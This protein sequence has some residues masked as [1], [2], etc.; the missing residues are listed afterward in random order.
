VV[1]AHSRGVLRSAIFSTRRTLTVDAA[2]SALP[3]VVAKYFSHYH[4]PAA[5]TITHTI[6]NIH[7]S[8]RHGSICQPRIPLIALIRNRR[9]KMTTKM[10]TIATMT[11]RVDK[12]QKM[13]D[14]ISSILYSSVKNIEGRDM[15]K[16]IQEAIDILHNLECQA[17]AMFCTDEPST[18][19]TAQ[20]DTNNAS[21]NHSKIS[22]GDENIQLQLLASAAISSVGSLE[23]LVQRVNRSRKRSRT[24]SG[25]AW[26]ALE[27]VVSSSIEA[28]SSK[29]R[30]SHALALLTAGLALSIGSTDPSITKMVASAVLP[31]DQIHL[32]QCG[33]KCQKKKASDIATVEGSEKISVEY[34]EQEASKKM[35][36]RDNDCDEAVK[37]QIYSMARAAVLGLLHLA[38]DKTKNQPAQSPVELHIVAKIESGFS[39]GD[40]GRKRGDKELAKAVANVVNFIFGRSSTSNDDVD[41]YTFGDAGELISK[42]LVAP[43]FSLVANIRPWDYV[44][45]EHLVRCA[46]ELDLWYSAELL[47]DA[48]IATTTQD[49]K[50]VMMATSFSKDATTEALLTDGRFNTSLPQ[51]SIGH[52]AAGAIIDITF[53]YRLYRRADA[54]ATKYYSFGGPER[55]VEA[56]FLHACD[57]ITKVVKRRQVQVIDKQIERVDA[58]VARVSKDLVLTSSTSN[59]DNKQRKF[60]GE[61]VAIETMSEHIRQ[62]TLRSLRASSLHAAAARLAKLWGLPY[63]HDPM[64]MAQELEARKLLYLQWDDECCPGN[65]SDTGGKEARPLPEPI[66][67]PV[68]VLTRFSEL[69]NS[70]YVGFD[71]EWH[72]TIRGVALLQLSTIGD[73]LLIDIPALTATKEGCDSLRDTVGKLFT[74]PQVLGV[75]EVVGFGCKDDIKRLRVSPCVASTHWFPQ[76]ERCTYKD[77]RHLIRELNPQLGGKGGLGF[78]LSSACDMF[79][80]K[81]LDKAEQCSDWLARPLSPEQREYA[82]LDAWSCAAIASKIFEERGITTAKKGLDTST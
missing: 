36:S 31:S 41:D 54:F 1:S 60:H 46:A 69:E 18:D 80:G 26:K 7:H 61:D 19:V 52:L 62:Y 74:K 58:S 11:T 42:D 21:I 53:D 59:N 6:C 51:D 3:E 22:E 71:C 72:D 45:V 65:S 49:D 68:E 33:K 2:P 67:D 64:Q 35:T 28:D 47:C 77:L 13:V 34:Q 12:D 39:V 66:R 9:D 44:Q 48:A 15:S 43:T 25:H 76:N 50:R 56:R 57:T 8:Q 10:T 37:N 32:P 4:P 29:L 81:H 40:H 14:R 75:Q 78:G 30:I 38:V 73:S 20:T 82:A 63:D 70:P 16:S 23:Q 24:S 27:S 55:F 17:R 79:L 5:F